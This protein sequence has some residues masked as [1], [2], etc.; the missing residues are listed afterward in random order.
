MKTAENGRFTNCTTAPFSGSFPDF[1]DR[2]YRLAA[3]R[4]TFCASQRKHTLC[5]QYNLIIA[6]AIALWNKKPPGIP[7][8]FLYENIQ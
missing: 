8:G 2:N 4:N 7:G 6:P 3:N 1:S 5:L